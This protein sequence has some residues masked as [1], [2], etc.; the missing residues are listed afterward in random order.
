MDMIGF[1]VSRYFGLRSFGQVYGLLFSIFTIGAG[2]GPYLVGI[3]FTVSHN[4]DRALL[5][6]GVLLATAVVCFALIGPYNYE[7]R[8]I[9]STAE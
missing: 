8:L 3:I 9:R 5:A 7:P 1:L 6:L 2:L 4:Y